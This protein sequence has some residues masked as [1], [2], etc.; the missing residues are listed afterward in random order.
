MR[1]KGGKEGT[2]R[3]QRTGLVELGTVMNVVEAEAATVHA[4]ALPQIRGEGPAAVAALNTVYPTNMLKD[5]LSHTHTH[6]C[7]F[8]ALERTK[9]MGRFVPV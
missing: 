4:V 7:G 5:C 6:H 8:P 3:W 1:E 9:L 2:L